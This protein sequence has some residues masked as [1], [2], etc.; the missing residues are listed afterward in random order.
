M[1]R[2]LARLIPLAASLALLAAA[3]AWAETRLEDEE[4]E[5]SAAQD[6]E[7][8]VAVDGGATRELRDFSTDRPDVSESPFTID[9]GHIQVE[10]TLIGYA[11][12]RADAAGVVTDSFEFGT[13][14]LRIGVSKQLELNLVWQPYGIA[15]PR[16]GGPTERGIGSATVR[17]KYNL[18]GNERTER[19]GD[20][21]LALL[22]YVTIPTDDGNGISDSEASF[23][24]I[25]PFAVALGDGFGLGLN[26]A[27][28]FTRPDRAT[29]YD[30]ALLASASLAYEITDKLGTYGEAVWQFSR[31]GEGDIVTLN[32][33]LT[34][35][36]AENWQLD[37]GVNVGVSSAADPIAPF[38]GIAARF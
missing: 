19:P 20:T 4:D 25:I 22:P 11:R 31:A 2:P 27:A 10:T 1:H 5:T 30:A 12:S 16:R 35:G 13:T 23:G 9:P 21:A 26:A 24:L 29:P 14:N 18:W 34:F 32:T 38:I 17:A 33:G 3:P 8:A 36:F 6:N 15:D 7:K 28:E 37:A